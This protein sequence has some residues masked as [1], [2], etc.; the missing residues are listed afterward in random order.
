MSHI[1]VPFPASNIYIGD[2]YQKKFYIVKEEPVY[3][4]KELFFC[5]FNQ[6]PHTYSKMNIPE[7]FETYFSYNAGKSLCQ[8][9]LR[10]KD[11]TL[12]YDSEDSEDEN[13]T[14][15]Y[16]NLNEFPELKKYFKIK[17]LSARL[18]LYG[19]SDG[20]YQLAVWNNQAYVVS[21]GNNVTSYHI[22]LDYKLQGGDD[23]TR[24]VILGDHFIVHNDG[25]VYSVVMI[26][27]N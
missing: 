12:L 19:Q 4:P 8:E 18:R 15:N 22:D 27:K 24:V 9:M 14:H 2:L 1:I 7:G 13:P 11:T 3:K 5:N 6:D 25:D 16:S 17:P 21:L 10:C 23:S 26:L 20:G